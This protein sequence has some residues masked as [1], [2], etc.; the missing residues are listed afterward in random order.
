VELAD[1]WAYVPFMGLYLALGCLG[2]EL[3]GR[4]GRREVRLG[5]AAVWVLAPALAL[6]VVQQRQL[7][8]WATSFTIYDQ[9]LKATSGN[10]LV[11]SNYGAL[12]LDQ[13]DEAAAEHYYLLSLKAYPDYP[14]ATYNYGMLRARQGRYAEALDLLLVAMRGDEK[15]HHAYDDYCAIAFCLE[16]LGRAGEAPD[17][18]V[19]AIDEEPRQPRA[20]NNWGNLA[21]NIGNRELARD[22][23]ARAL[24]VA[25]D[26]PLARENMRRLMAAEP[27]RPEK[28]AEKP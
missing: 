18:Y 4:V 10:Y 26:D 1:R 6:G 15:Q 9:A 13:N 24:E 20:Y 28:R 7:A 12:K 2:A 22:L 8:T 19:R 21:W 3:I 27:A 16:Q 14:L 17:Y 5:L 25:P 11:L 23:Y